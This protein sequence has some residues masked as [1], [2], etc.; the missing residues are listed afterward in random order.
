MKRSRLVLVVILV[1]VA[2]L[3]TSLWVN[4]GPLWRW[5]MVV[6]QPIAHLK[7]DYRG[8]HLVNRWT[9]RNIVTEAFY[10]DTGFRVLYRREVGNEVRTTRWNRQG[11]VEAQTLERAGESTVSLSGPPWRWGL[12]DQTEPTAPWWGKE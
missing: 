8:T 10:E 9:R 11:H 12:T 1:A 7:S 4:E 2:A 6:E 3:V 5:V